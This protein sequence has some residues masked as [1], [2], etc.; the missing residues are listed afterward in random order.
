MKTKIAALITAL[1]IIIVG[2]GG[3]YYIS[4]N[5]P[6]IQG[7]TDTSE[8]TGENAIPENQ[9]V[10][11]IEEP[12]DTRIE[13]WLK[14][15][16]KQLGLDTIN[17]NDGTFIWEVE[18]GQEEVQGQSLLI[19]SVS[20]GTLD[21]VAGLFDEY[22]FVQNEINTEN[23]DFTTYGFQKDDIVCILKTSEIE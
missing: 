19:E 6:E 5:N 23:D 13:D 3:V 9:S 12:T 2:A 21:T 15:I 17:I 16:G 22:D 20:D 8:Q 1:L 4:Q 7:V 18:I 11:Y 14:F 10:R